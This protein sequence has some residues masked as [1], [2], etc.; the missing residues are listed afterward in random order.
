MRSGGEEGLEERGDL[1]LNWAVHQLVARSTRPDIDLNEVRDRVE[2]D[3]FR[4]PV[5]VEV[6]KLGVDLNELDLTT[7]IDRLEIRVVGLGRW[8]PAW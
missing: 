2:T 6:T 8:V 3:E 4:S 7:R 1:N 5:D